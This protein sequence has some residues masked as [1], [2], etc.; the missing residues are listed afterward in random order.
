MKTVFFC[1]KCFYVGAAEDSEDHR[2]PK[3]AGLLYRTGMDRDAYVALTPEEKQAAASLWKYESSQPHGRI[4]GGTAEPGSNGIAAMMKIIGII[5]YVIAG[6]AGLY[7]LVSEA[8]LPGLILL[9]SGF[10]SGTLFLGFGEIIRLLD[11]ISKKN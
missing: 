7:L 10:V 1:P 2:C 5:V 11:V 9:G 3:C 6:L 4:G 8:L